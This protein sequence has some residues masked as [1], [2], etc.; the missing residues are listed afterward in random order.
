MPNPK[1]P[2]EIDVTVGRNVRRIRNMIGISQEALAAK[3]GLTFQ[4]VQKYEKGTNRISA[5]KLVAMSQALDCSIAQLF[6]D[7]EASTNTVPVPNFSVAALKLAGEFDK[8]ASDVQ[9]TAVA[10]LI[11]SLAHHDTTRPALAEE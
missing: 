9:R 2:N 11:Q 5:S 8:I 1:S 10:K 4:Q 6:A 3:L 7:V